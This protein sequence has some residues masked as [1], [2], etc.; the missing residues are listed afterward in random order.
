VTTRKVPVPVFE[1][2]RLENDTYLFVKH[3]IFVD[4]DKVRCLHEKIRYEIFDREDIN[5]VISDDEDFEVE[6]DEND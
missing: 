3:L 1:K 4:A 5:N 2:E 6:L